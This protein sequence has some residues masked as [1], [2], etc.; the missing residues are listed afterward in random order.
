MKI[1]DLAARTGVPPRMLRYSDQQGLLRPARGENGYR[2]YSE[3][4][5]EE[6]RPCAA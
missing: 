3:A 6:R 4:D 5:V 2:R 1:G